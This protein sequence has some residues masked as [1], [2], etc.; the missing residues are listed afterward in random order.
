VVGVGLG[1]SRKTR[2]RS[3]K[4]SE[5]VIRIHDSTAVAML[6]PDLAVTNTMVLRLLDFLF[7]L[8][9]CLSP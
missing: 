9:V 4:R 2:V 7:V 3:E 8:F 1:F 5:R 6:D